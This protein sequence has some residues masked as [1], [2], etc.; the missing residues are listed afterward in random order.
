MVGYSPSRPRA[1]AGCSPDR[2][3]PAV[4]VVSGP[5]P[6]S[7]DVDRTLHLE[8]AAALSSRVGSTQIGDVK[9]ENG[10]TVYMEI[11]TNS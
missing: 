7:H 11:V 9:S 2:R 5:S 8:E 6:R 4:K 10:S 1:P 3:T